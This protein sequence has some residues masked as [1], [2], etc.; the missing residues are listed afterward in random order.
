MHQQQGDSNSSPAKLC[1]RMHR[2][3]GINSALKN[4]SRWRARTSLLHAALRLQEEEE[5]EER[6]AKDLFAFN[7]AIEIQAEMQHIS[8]RT[9]SGAL[10]QTEAAS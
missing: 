8:A 4:D 5:E 3:L 7:D 2:S 6:V 9:P 1:A 10:T